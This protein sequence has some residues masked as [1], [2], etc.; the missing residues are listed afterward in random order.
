VP[1][2]A[3]FLL[4]VGFALIVVELA[5][6][7]YWVSKTLRINAVRVPRVRAVR[8]YVT[9]YISYSEMSGV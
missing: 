4:I 3:V 1:G 5:Y 2:Y 6:V 9:K 8:E 7:G